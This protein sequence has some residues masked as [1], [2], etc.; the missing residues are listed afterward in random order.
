MSVIKTIIMYSRFGV[1]QRNTLSCYREPYVKIIV[2]LL[3]DLFE[4]FP[5]TY[6]KLSVL[7][8]R[9]STFLHGSQIC[10][11]GHIFSLAISLP[12]K[13]KDFELWLD[14]FKL[15]FLRGIYKLLKFEKGILGG[16]T[17]AVKRYTKDN[18][19]Q[20]ENHYDPDK[21]G[22]IFNI[23]MQETFKCGQ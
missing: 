6:L 1:P 5:N 7:Q 8:L 17:Q 23:W 20:M 13:H 2:L 14:Q 19:K 12:S 9:F 3:L 11:A 21:K 16:I 4:T 22:H 18:N 10:I 15:Q